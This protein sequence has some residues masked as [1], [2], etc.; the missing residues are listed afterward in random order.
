MQ[1][2]NHLRLQHYQLQKERESEK[3]RENAGGDYT[4]VL[5]CRRLNPGYLPHLG[6]LQIW[7]WETRAQ[8]LRDKIQTT[9]LYTHKHGGMS[10]LNANKGNFKLKYKQKSKILLFK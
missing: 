1:S 10:D 5:W 4:W 7:S 9:V 8:E 2:H 6:C 3:E